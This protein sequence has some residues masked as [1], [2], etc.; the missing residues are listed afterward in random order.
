MIFNRKCPNN[1]KCLDTPRFYTLYTTD[2]KFVNPSI[3]T[4]SISFFSS[5]DTHES[6]HL[7]GCHATVINSSFKALRFSDLVCHPKSLTLIIVPESSS[8]KFSS[9]R[10]IQSRS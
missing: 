9:S 3:N 7:P 6:Y 2:A 8:S 10:L 1:S 5:P 4:G